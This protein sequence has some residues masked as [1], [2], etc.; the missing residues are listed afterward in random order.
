MTH[1][2]CPWLG[3]S[4]DGVIQ[5]TNGLVEVKWP[6]MFRESSFEDVFSVQKSK[7]CL[8]LTPNSLCLRCKHAY[9]MPVVT[10]LFITKALYCDFVVWS[11]SEFHIERIFPD[12]SFAS[13]H[14][15]K[16]RVFYF[17]HMPPALIKLP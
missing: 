8:K 16:L 15:E 12:P 6:F 10:Q 7:F 5:A 9:Y 4:P 17:I 11:P 1:P 2:D 3:A 13:V 14:L